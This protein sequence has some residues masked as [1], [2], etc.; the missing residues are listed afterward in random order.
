[1][2]TRY[3]DPELARYRQSEQEIDRLFAE[4]GLKATAG[5]IDRVPNRFQFGMLPGAEPWR[6]WD[7]QFVSVLTVAVPALSVALVVGWT[8]RRKP[9]Q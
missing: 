7:G 6:V 5:L 2:F 9:G 8:G 4:A 3:Y 1:M